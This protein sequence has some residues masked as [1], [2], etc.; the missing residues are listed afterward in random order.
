MQSSYV[1]SLYMGQRDTFKWWWHHR[2]HRVNCPAPVAGYTLAW[3]LCL[4]W[5]GLLIG[6]FVCLLLCTLCS[7]ALD[8]SLGSY[9]WLSCDLWRLTVRAG[10]WPRI[11]GISGPLL[12]LCIVLRGATFWGSPPGP[13]D[14][15]R[16]L[17]INYLGA[18]CIGAQP[19]VHSFEGF[20]CWGTEFLNTY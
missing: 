10:D 17:N 4:V 19:V 3:L 15:V 18:G 20:A 11:S 12:L 2:L 1:W 9:D 7:L 13:A 16:V 14:G 6:S 5:G 8:C